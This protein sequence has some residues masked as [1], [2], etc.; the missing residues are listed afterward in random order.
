[1]SQ[2]LAPSEARL[3]IDRAPEEIP[4]LIGRKR[5]RL[6]YLDH[7]E[8]RGWDLFEKAS[9][10]DLEGIVAKRKVSLYR[11]MEKPSPHW[12]KIK[13]PDYSQAIGREEF[14]ER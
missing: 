11:P 1:M 8:S 14:F 13:N 4:K 10:L 3:A 6:L 7:I 5:S 9:D 2:I 12:I